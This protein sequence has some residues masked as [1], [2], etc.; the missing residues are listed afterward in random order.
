MY[1]CE[2][3]IFLEELDGK[4]L[5]W[6]DPYLGRSKINDTL[7]AITRVTDEGA[8]Y[9]RKQGEKVKEEKIALFGSTL[10]EDF[11]KSCLLASHIQLRS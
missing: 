6:F 7:I 9:L 4:D 10:A 2:K 1:L 11:D 3:D 8:F 5:V